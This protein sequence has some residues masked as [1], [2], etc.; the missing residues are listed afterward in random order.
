M[1]RKIGML[2]TLTRQ[3]ISRLLEKMLAEYGID[4]FNGPQGRILYVLWG[5]D[6]ISIQEL[7]NGTGL[8]NATLTSMLDRMER[9]ELVRRRP[10]PGD[11]R[12]T[13]I[14]LTPKARALEHE[15]QAVSERMSELTCR[16]LSEEECR[17]LEAAL[18]RVL[19]NVR[20]AEQRL[21]RPE[22]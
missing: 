21:N 1:E 4:E 3:H 13:L 10:A 20:E 22:K 6:S 11:R 2:I 15:Y 12:K 16:G 14:A 8:A 9:K 17:R 5:R 18:E 7:A 19:D